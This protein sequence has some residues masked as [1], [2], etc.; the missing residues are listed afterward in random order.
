[1][2]LGRSRLTDVPIAD[3]TVSEFHVEIAAS[4]R[5]IEVRD[6]NSYNGT[7]YEGARLVEAVLDPGSV[8]VIGESAVRVDAA[9]SHAVPM[10]PRDSFHGLIGRTPAMLALYAAI[11]RVGPTDL[12]VLVEGPTGSG[13]E[14]AARALHASGHPERPFTVLDCAS[15]PAMLAE[16]VLFGHVRGAFTGATETRMGVFEAA[17]GGTVFLDEIGELPLTLQPKLLRVLEQRLVT[18]IGE[19]KPRPVNVRVLSATWRDLRRMVN[20]G[21]FRDDLYFRLAQVRLEIP[22]L[23]ERPDDVE[24]LAKEFLRRMPR[25][26]PCARS[27][28]REALAELRTRPLPGNVRELR[29]VVERA[30]V[31]CEGPSIRPHDLA[32]DR[33]LERGREGGREPEGEQVLDFKIAKRTAIDDFEREFLERLLARTEGNIAKAA[34]LAAVE[35]HYL[36]SLLKKHG[37]HES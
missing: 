7:F 30:A 21:L 25:D 17:D 12:N 19:T 4:D 33:L 26:V 6:L 22:P 36:R 35:R 29:N 8:I 11:E 3:V 37:L 24:L 31:L 10:A 13:K 32:V 20:Q 23:S 27:F 14:V 1:V 28:T 9:A 18:R 16:S 34:A 15:V 2:T 5:G